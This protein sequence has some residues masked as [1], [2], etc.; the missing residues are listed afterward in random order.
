[1]EIQECQNMTKSAAVLHYH[2][3]QTSAAVPEVAR[4]PILWLTVR[5][6]T[7][8]TDAGVDHAAGAGLMYDLS[9]MKGIYCNCEF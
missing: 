9:T 3:P 7:E 1:M 5:K 6:Y 2:W 4:F 8:Y